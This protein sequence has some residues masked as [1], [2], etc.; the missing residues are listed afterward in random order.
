MLDKLMDVLNEY[1]TDRLFRHRNYICSKGS[2][3]SVAYILFAGERV[4]I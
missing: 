4:D 2:P 1:R 3:E